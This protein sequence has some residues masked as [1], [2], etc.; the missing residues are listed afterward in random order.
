MVLRSIPS[1]TT[2]TTTTT[3]TTQPTPTTLLILGAGWTSHFLLPLLQHHRIPHAATTRTGHSNTIPFTFDPTDPSLEPYERLPYARSVLVTF[4]LRGSGEARELTGRYLRTHSAPGRRSSVEAMERAK[5]D[6]GSDSD[7]QDSAFTASNEGSDTERTDVHFI[8]LGSSGIYNIP[9]NKS[10]TDRHAPYD[11][12]SARAQAEDELL[13]IR[14]RGATVLCLAGLWGGERDPSGWVGRVVR[15]K[16][17]VR[18]KGA[19]H[20]VHGVDVA[21]AILGVLWA[22]GGDGEG[23]DACGEVVRV[24]DGEGV[25]RRGQRWI[26]CDLR[27][28]DWWDLFMSWGSGGGKGDGGTS[29]VV[30]SYGDGR[31]GA[32]VGDAGIPSNG[33][34]NDGNGDDAKLPVRKWVLELMREEDI[35]ALPRSRE[36]LGRVLDAREFWETVGMT[37]EHTRAGG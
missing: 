26:V 20:L 14:P 29:G 3:T 34:F 37:P 32:G 13:R 2:P 5:R 8:L 4:P 6:S 10:F 19:V 24:R 21:R 23:G 28:Y 9:T 16:E 18:G 15:S 12:D 17:D 36:K 22:M 7:E 35:P 30:S 25:R 31:E 33:L 27:G 1:T 11:R